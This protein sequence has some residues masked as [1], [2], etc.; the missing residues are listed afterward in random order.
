MISVKSDLLI[1]GMDEV[2]RLRYASNVVNRKHF[3]GRVL[4][5]RP[6]RCLALAFDTGLVIK[7]SKPVVAS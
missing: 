1:A 3:P 7:A 4:P 2:R 5:A 6:A